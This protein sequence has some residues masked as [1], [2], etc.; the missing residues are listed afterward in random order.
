[1]KNSPVGE[2]SRMFAF[3]LNL[4]NNFGY[5]GSSLLC[6]GSLVAVHGPTYPLACGIL[7][8]RPGIQ[9]TSPALE[10]RFLIATREVPGCLLSW[11]K[12]WKKW[13][14]PRSGSLRVSLGKA[15]PPWA[16]VLGEVPVLG[17]EL[18]LWG[19]GGCARQGWGPRERW[20]NLQEA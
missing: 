1:M 3:F 7:V 15:R 13:M 6:L 16:V 9:P 14:S 8:S 11:G 17:L 20:R 10:G 19:G 2:V 12:I 5:A 4:K 18:G